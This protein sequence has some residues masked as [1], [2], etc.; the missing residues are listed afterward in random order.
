[1]SVEL[2]ISA[3][4]RSSGKSML[5]MGLARAACLRQL[6]VQTFKKGPDYIDPLWLKA[7]STRP[8]FNLDP[9]LQSDAELA[10]TFDSHLGEA[11]VVLVEGTMGLHDGLQSDG[12]DSNAAIAK[13][14][15][16]PVLLIV[17]C[18]G[19]HRTVAALINGVHAFDPELAFAGVILNRVRSSRHGQK[20]DQAVREHT[21]LT[22]FGLV[23]EAPHILISEK[24]LGLVPAPEH[25]A[26][27]QH[28][29]G[30]AALLEQHC[31]LDS[32]FKTTTATVPSAVRAA[33]NVTAAQSS[34][35]WV[36]P[37]QAAIP[38]PGI[39]QPDLVQPVIP[40]PTTKTIGNGL[41]IGIARDAA[42]HFYYQDDLD[43]LLSRGVELIEI[44]PM[45]G[46]FPSNLH[47]LIIGGGFPERHVQQLAA[48]QAF[49][50][51]L[52]ESI[53]AGLV[54]HAECA[55]LMYLCRSIR[56]DDT[57]YPMVG[58]IAGDVALQDAPLGRGY[59]RLRCQGRS[60]EPGVPGGDCNNRVFAAHEF[61]HS[62][63][64]FDYDPDFVYRVERGYGVDGQN[65][66]I[67]VKNV[68]ATYAHLRHTKNSPWVDWFLD[69]IVAASTQQGAQTCLK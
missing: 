8:C 2:F 37:V 68:I 19:M 39:V 65:D 63:A 7:A 56:L 22:L 26:T 43:T 6:S 64:S 61:H 57:A 53:E 44:S 3:P 47:G 69:R 50:A 9:Y 4:W 66:G 40:R 33:T 27:L 35:A 59:M 41:V 60:G 28:I 54:V 16:L 17:D 36:D 55:G 21:D 29:D 48:N 12:S 30:T 1:M 11:S 46:N 25:Q 67:R 10:H 42:F 20:L 24:A 14:L 15:N 51:G 52:L 38:R 13:R 45:T 23:P 62:K 32:V 34:N 18:R 5:T 49:R 58:A 31:D